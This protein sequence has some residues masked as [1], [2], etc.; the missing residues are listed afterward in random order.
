MSQAQPWEAYGI[1]PDYAEDVF[2]Q[3]ALNETEH[4]TGNKNNAFKGTRGMSPAAWQW[5]IVIGALALLWLGHFH[6][7]SAFKA[8][9]P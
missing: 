3:D 5:F 8:V 7:R 1:S 2:G 6:F 4:I 9:L